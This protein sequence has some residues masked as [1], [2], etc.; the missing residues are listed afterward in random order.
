MALQISDPGIIRL[1]PDTLAGAFAALLSI[2]G[3]GVANTDP[4]AR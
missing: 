3:N 4:E 1:G 2:V